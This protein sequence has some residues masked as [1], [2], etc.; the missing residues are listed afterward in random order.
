MS[1]LNDIAESVWHGAPWLMIGYFLFINTSFLVLTGLAA[2]EFVAHTRRT[3]FRGYE[4]VF[5]NAL[6]PP[7]SV[8]M[9]AYNERSG[10]VE[11]VR[12]MTSLRYPEYEVIVI[13]DGSTDDTLTVLVEAFGLVEVPKVVPDDV[14]TV[15]AVR[16]VYMSPYGARNVVV[17]HKE[18]GGKSDA[19]N[20]GINIARYPLVC[21]VDADSVL[22]PD[23][24]LHVTQPFADDPSRVIATGG[25]VRAA[26]GCLV[27]AGRVIDVR[28]PRRWL[29]RIQVVEYLRAFLI[30]RAGWS[31][32]GALLIISGAF[33]LFR[34]DAVIQVGGMDRAT[35]GED[36][37]LVVRLHRTYAERH[38]D[39]RI[40]FVTE[41][42][43]W[44]EVPEDRGVLGRQRRRWQR[45]ITEI[46]MRHRRMIGN[47]RYGAVGLLAMP[48]YLVFEVIAPFV[49]LFGLVYLVAV[50]GWA[51]LHA[52]GAVDTP[53]DPTL[54]LVLLAVSWGYSVLLTVVAMALEEFSFRRY[55][56]KRDLL[57]AL[58]A[59]LLENIGYRQITAWWRVRGTL[60]ALRSS[61]PEW[62]AMTR[63]GF[64]DAAE[65]AAA[66][67]KQ[68]R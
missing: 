43:A 25:V 3:R 10:I 37:E 19:L 33:G 61:P 46:L 40:V 30:G 60:Q 62:G 55:H 59:T 38:Q 15:G 5:G 22:D 42:V 29:P 47:A 65:D 45:G 66:A 51:A 2:G 1:V 28:M 17:V 52:A 4:E 31:R 26:N 9:P 49:E 56:R 41:P 16:R 35:L 36:A 63:L 27:K 23:A 57:A 12:A 50:G 21:M 24:L 44:T 8:L 58:A 39:Q 54:A 18:N 20:T 13:D 11:A 34:R 67:G 6:T 68:Q 64:T 48:W 53:V 7:V 32:A 14:P